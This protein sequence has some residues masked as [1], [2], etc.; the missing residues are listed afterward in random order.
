MYKCFD[1]EPD[2]WSWRE[3]VKPAAGGTSRAIKWLT[4]GA[5]HCRVGHLAEG[6]TNGQRELGVDYNKAIFTSKLISPLISIY[7][8]INHT[9]VLFIL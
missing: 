4:E 1:G 8:N 2:R 6:S 5:G 9:F 7:M 3:A